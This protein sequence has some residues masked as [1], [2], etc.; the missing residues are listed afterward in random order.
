MN[1]APRSHH[2]SSLAEVRKYPKR[3]VWGP[4]VQVHDIGTRYTIVEYECPMDGGAIRFHIYV[5]G[6]DISVSFNTFE[7]AMVGAVA[8]GKLPYNEAQTAALYAYKVL[9][10][11]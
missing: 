1:I 3:F 9:T 2:V 5:D 10:P 6:K 8:F 7:E 4:V 11:R